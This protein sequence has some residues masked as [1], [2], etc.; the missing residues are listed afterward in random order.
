MGRFLSNIGYN[1]LKTNSCGNIKDYEEARNAGA[2]D[3]DNDVS[4]W[5]PSVTEESTLE[6]LS[7]NDI[8]AN[9]V[10]GKNNC[11]WKNK[12]CPA[13]KLGFNSK[14]KPVNCHGYDSYIH[15]K[16]KCMNT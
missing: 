10:I 6:E 12:K 3:E 1:V 2:N 16:V 7:C 11:P 4:T 8:Y 13:C 14:L 9:R 5:I 15:P